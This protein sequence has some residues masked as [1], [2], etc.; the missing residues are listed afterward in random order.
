MR[1]LITALLIAAVGT[2]V[3]GS[4]CTLAFADPLWDSC[5][6]LAQDRVGPVGQS[7]HRA[8]EG[9]VLQCLAGKSPCLM[10]RST[11]PWRSAPSMTETSG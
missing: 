7:T 10:L 8:Y 5:H 9:F 6:K 11:H 2:A 1:A 3:A 4:C